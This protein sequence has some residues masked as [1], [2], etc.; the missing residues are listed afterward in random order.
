MGSCTVPSLVQQS[1]WAR[2]IRN[3]SFGCDAE[4]GALWTAKCRGVFRCNEGDTH[5]VRCGF[6]PGQS[7]YSCS[8]DRQDR[9]STARIAAQAQRPAQLRSNLSIALQVSGHV[10]RH[11]VCE[12]RHLVAHLRACR[13]TFAICD[14][15][16][17]TWDEIAPNTPSWKGRGG[18]GR[19]RRPELMQSSL[20]CFKTIVAQTKPIASMLRGYVHTEDENR[21]FTFTGYNWGAAKLRGFRN[22]IAGMRGAAVLRRESGRR[23]SL[24]M[25][26]RPDAT[27]LHEPV[28][29]LWPCLGALA[30]V[31]KGI[32][33]CRSTA[34]DGGVEDDNCFFGDPTNMDALVDHLHLQYDRVFETATNDPKY[35]K[36]EFQFGIALRQLGLARAH[37]DMNKA[38]LLGLNLS[39]SDFDA[40]ER[41]CQEIQDP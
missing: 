26:F 20:A 39:E 32:S 21:T 5:K 34:W 11:G 1:S 14:L 31:P 41:P 18:G 7:F 19:A 28:D 29:T 17:H 4:S 22:N 40:F 23:Y 15:Y 35:A 30:W 33:A 38:R 37:V 2:C 10:G 9:P 12:Y 3:I 6:P 8:C 16:L 13:K 36:V 27:V 25:R 24:A